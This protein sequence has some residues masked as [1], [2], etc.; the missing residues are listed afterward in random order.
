MLSQPGLW[1]GGNLC[2]CI[3]YLKISVSSYMFCMYAWIKSL[4]VKL[5]SFLHKITPLSTSQVKSPFYLSSSSVLVMLREQAVK[6]CGLL[7]LVSFS[8]KE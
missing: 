3:R 2:R 5:I 1:A 7:G 8:R 4:Q 6:V